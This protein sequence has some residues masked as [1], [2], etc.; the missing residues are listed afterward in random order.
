M[1]LPEVKVVKDGYH[2]K[3]YINNKRVYP[4][5]KHG[6]R[7]SIKYGNFIIK[8]NHSFYYHK[9]LEQYKKF[10]I[11]D[12]RY[13]PKCYFDN[14]EYSIHE[15]VYHIRMDKHNE[16]VYYDEYNKACELKEKYD[17]RDFESCQLG[18]RRKSKSRQVKL[19]YFDYGYRYES[20][21]HRSR[22]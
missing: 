5:D 21:N 2:K 16:A 1:K 15:Y 12:R 6:C 8:F 19:V 4:N 17:L 14:G 10:S 22:D 18:I 20:T 13:F 9:D 7:M 11:Y 3:Y